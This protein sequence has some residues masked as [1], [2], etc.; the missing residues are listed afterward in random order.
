MWVVKRNLS[1]GQLTQGCQTQ[2]RSSTGTSFTVYTTYK[3]NINF[4]HLYTRNCAR[5]MYTITVADKLTQFFFYICPLVTTCTRFGRFLASLAHN[6]LYDKEVRHL[7]TLL[8]LP[9][10]GMF[11]P[12]CNFG[13]LT[14]FRARADIT[15]RMLLCN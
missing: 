8:S 9:R 1:R 13:I 15:W 2:E 3:N 10:I 5:K 7:A 4:L 11:G 14:V 12:H 6:N